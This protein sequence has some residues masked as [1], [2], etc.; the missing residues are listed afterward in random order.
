MTPEVSQPASPVSLFSSRLA[1]DAAAFSP[2]ERRILESLACKVRAAE[3]LDEVMNYLFETTR[4]ICPCDRISLVFLEDDGQV[5]LPGRP[6][7]RSLGACQ[8][9]VRVR[10]SQPGPRLSARAAASTVSQILPPANAR[11]PLPAGL[12]YR[13]VQRLAG[14]RLARRSRLGLQRSGQ[15]GRIRI[16]LA[17]A[18]PWEFSHPG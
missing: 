6:H 5:R 3:T 12:R 4:P 8:R 18:H 14:D 7:R 17:A 10:R 2:H 1:V 15:M 16:P 9:C 11:T 13:S